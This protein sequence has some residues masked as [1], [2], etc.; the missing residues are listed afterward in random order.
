MHVVLM[1]KNVHTPRDKIHQEFIL[2]E[3]LVISTHLQGNI[4]DVSFAEMF[5]NIFRKLRGFLNF[6]F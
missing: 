4:F 6:L 2:Q 1:N 3:S 5:S